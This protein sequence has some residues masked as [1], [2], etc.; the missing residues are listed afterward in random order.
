MFLLS[1]YYSA[2]TTN[3]DVELPPVTFRRTRGDSLSDSQLLRDTAEVNVD[4]VDVC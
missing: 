2:A 3:S 1:Y 4:T